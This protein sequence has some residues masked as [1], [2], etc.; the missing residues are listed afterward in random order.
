M[1]NAIVEENKFE[2]TGEM[3]RKQALIRWNLLKAKIDQAKEKMKN[4]A[5]RTGEYA[6]VP[7]TLYYKFKADN[8][9]W[10]FTA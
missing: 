6:D 4:L 10:I 9:V 3:E 8:V 7:A 2:F 5:D 1:F